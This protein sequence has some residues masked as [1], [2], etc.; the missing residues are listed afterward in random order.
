[1]DSV[2]VEQLKRIRYLTVLLFLLNVVALALAAANGSSI[3]LVVLLIV[4][5][6]AT[7][8]LMVVLRSRSMVWAVTRAQEPVLAL[9]PNTG[10]ATES[11]YR[12]ML[13]LE[14]RRSV[15]EFAPLTVLRIH[16]GEQ[17]RREH[18]LEL[19]RVLGEE[20]SRPGDLIGWE[21]GCVIGAVLPSTNENARK[22][23]ERC[24]ARVQGHELTATLPLRIVAKTFQPRG[25]LSLGKVQQHLEQQ[26]QEA[27]QQP[28]GVFFKAE[29]SNEPASPGMM[30]TDQ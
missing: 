22:L 25:E 26:L 24:F 6:L 23:V 3:T 28:P 18:L 5:L 27:L 21:Q 13:A 8:L 14:C 16:L 9:D 1:M 19:V 15:R 11:W 10:I 12:H 2:F 30:Y 4:L 29:E 20:F 17:V 7:T